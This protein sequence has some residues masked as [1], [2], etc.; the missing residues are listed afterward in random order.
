MYAIHVCNTL[1][2]YM[3]CMGTMDMDT[4]HQQSLADTLTQGLLEFFWTGGCLGQTSYPGT[5]LA[6]LLM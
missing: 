5:A 3:H 1:W 6:I 4:G 2:H